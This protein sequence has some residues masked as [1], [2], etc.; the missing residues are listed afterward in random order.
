M[1]ADMKHADK[2]ALPRVDEGLFVLLT[3]DTEAGIQVCIYNRTCSTCSADSLL[4]CS[5]QLGT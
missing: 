3:C 2:V 4:T 1:A 5:V